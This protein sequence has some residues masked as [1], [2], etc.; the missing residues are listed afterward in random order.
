[1]DNVAVDHYVVYRGTTEE[2]VADETSQIG[3]STGPGYLDLDLTEG[4]WYYRVAAVD[5]V[6]NASAPSE[7]V[8]VFVDI[9][10]DPPSVPTGLTAQLTGA[11]EV[12]LDWDASTDDVG[13]AGYRVYRG[14]TPTFVADEETLVDEVEATQFTDTAVPYGVAYYQ[15]TAYDE[16]G[17]E[18]APTGVVSVVVPTTVEAIADTMVA[19]VNPTFVYGSQNQISAR[20]P[21]SGS[22]IESYLTFD[23][24]AAP[25][26]LT[27]TGAELSVTTSND[28]TANSTG[29]HQIS[30]LTGEWSEATTT[31][32]NRPTTGFGAQVGELTGATALNTTYTVT[33][34]AAALAS[35][36]GTEVS[37]A[38]RSTSTD[39]VRLYSREHT[40]AAARPTL[41]LTYTLVEPD[42]QAPSVPSGLSGSGNVA[43]EVSLQWSPSTD[44]VGVAGYRVY[45]GDTASFVA[46]ETSLVGDVAV[47]EFAED[48]VP[49]GTWYYRVAA[50]DAAGNASA[51][52]A[53][54]EVVVPEEEPEPVVVEITASADTM[55]A[56]NNA[57]YV[58]GSNNQLSSRGQSGSNLESYLTFELPAAPAGMTLT[59]AI[60][61]VT[62]SNDSTATTAGTHEIRLLSGSWSEASTTWNNRSVTV[63]NLL[64]Q[65]SSAPALNT[66][67]TITLD[68]AQLVAFLNGDLNLAMVSG[69]T[70]NLRI[71]SREHTVDA[72]RPTLILTFSPV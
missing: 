43:G 72:A 32:N 71:Y 53:A 34:N 28:P 7:V 23:L 1:V 46:D 41:T 59:G 3:T 47:T 50:Y 21:A 8:A 68:A 12:S 16:A 20:S 63:G 26:G 66:P 62:T 9:D 44:N 2:F 60:L 58:Y 18:S 39:N 65:L 61:R 70:D 64:G 40:V 56:E 36:A 42:T 69:S 55:V 29:E 24:P 48:E 13:V 17:N 38:L 54:F 35:L 10:T 57:N 15:V 11:G 33:L 4:M 19:Q 45:R 6:G 25:E 5:A 67:Y 49:T 52:S 31:W 27:L 22:T 30:L 14:T 51:A 37:F